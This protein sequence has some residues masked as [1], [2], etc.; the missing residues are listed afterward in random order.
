M[1]LACVDGASGRSGFTNAAGSA[2]DHALEGGVSS[3]LQ[4]LSDAIDDK[5][6][7]GKLIWYGEDFT[8]TKVPSLADALK[9]VGDKARLL[10]SLPETRSSTPWID[11][12]EK[13]L[14][15]TKA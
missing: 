8:G 7:A 9:A 10:L 4:T 12:L 6:T 2:D 11:E 14:K 15:S 13:V 5:E 3:A 1:T